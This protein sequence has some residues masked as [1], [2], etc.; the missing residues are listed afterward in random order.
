MCPNYF[1]QVRSIS[2]GGEHARIYPPYINE[3]LGYIN[4]I[5]HYLID[6]LMS[7]RLLL[8]SSQVWLYLILQKQVSTTV[9]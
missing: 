7:I 9:W 6:Y 2:G 1:D 3:G 5:Q 8:N 4:L